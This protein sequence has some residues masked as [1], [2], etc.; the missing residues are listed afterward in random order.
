MVKLRFVL[1]VEYH[2]LVCTFLLKYYHQWKI[3]SI[4]IFLTPLEFVYPFKSSVQCIC[5][6]VLCSFKSFLSAFYWFSRKDIVLLDL[7]SNYGTCNCVTFEK[8][9]D[10][11][12][13]EQGK[14][15]ISVIN[16]F[17]NVILLV[18]LQHIAGPIIIYLYACVGFNLLVLCVIYQIT[19]LAKSIKV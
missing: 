10:C 2:L 5:L 9:R 17:N 3:N 4:S 7:I 12:R 19:V 16:P 11:R 6:C 1:K 18:C 14:F 15:L 8:Q 13:E